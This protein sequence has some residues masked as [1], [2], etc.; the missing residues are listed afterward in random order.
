MQEPVQLGGIRC[1]FY[2]CIHPEFAT[3]SDCCIGC[4]RASGTVLYAYAL[5]EAC[6][7]VR[8]LF[9]FEWALP[10]TPCSG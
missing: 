1:K 9:L 6:F 8:K 3:L 10:S 5:A 2:Y 4:E 7:L